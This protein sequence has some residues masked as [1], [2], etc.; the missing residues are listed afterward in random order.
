[1]NTNTLKKLVKDIVSQAKALKD[2]HTLEP[3]APVNYACI[4]AQSDTEY[5][6]LI[7]ATQTIGKVVK[8]MNS[9]L[10]YHITDLETVA[11][12]LRILKIRIPDPTKPERGDADFTVADYPSFKKECLS[13]PGF[14]LIT[15]TDMEMIE[16]MEL[17][18]TARAYFSNPPVDQ[19]LL[20][21]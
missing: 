15:R 19:Q 20:G 18:C 11:G 12:V 3:N 21:S 13:R 4:F 1:M 17:N 14:K 8:E 7:E 10:L 16:L 9:G 2:R 5:K 6:E